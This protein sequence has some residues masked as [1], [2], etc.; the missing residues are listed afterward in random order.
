MFVESWNAKRAA[1]NNINLYNKKLALVKKGTDGYYINDITNGESS[2]SNTTQQSITT[3]DK[4]YF[5]DTVDKSGVWLAGASAYTDT[6]CLY[7][8]NTDGRIVTT[9]QSGKSYG[10]RPVVCLRASLPAQKGTTTDFEI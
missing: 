7:S 5:W 3:G 9:A 10:V 1:T 6:Y 4:L 8:I 2:A